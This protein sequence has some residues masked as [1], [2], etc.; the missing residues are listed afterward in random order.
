[1]KFCLLVLFLAIP[2]AVAAPEKVPVRPAAEPGPAAP[3]DLDAGVKLRIDG[4][5]KLLK[6]GKIDGA[7]ARLFEG[8][9]IAGEQ[10][11]LLS[12]LAKNTTKV[13]EKCGNLE[14][15]SLMRVRTAGKTLKEVVYIANCQKRPVRWQIYVYYG[16]GRWQVLDTDVQ[17]ELGSFFDPE[18][19]AASR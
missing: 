5:F 19:P 9:T 18:P 8:T 12:S 1:M 13:F 6:E 14:S 7:Y 10:P 3:A 16:G 11:E 17:I 2:P 15:A 4:F